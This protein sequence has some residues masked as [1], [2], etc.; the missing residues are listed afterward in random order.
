MRKVTRQ[1]NLVMRDEDAR[2][3][4]QLQQRLNLSNKSDVVRLALRRL[5]DAEGVK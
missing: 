1:F 5:A 3:L 2:L 4:E